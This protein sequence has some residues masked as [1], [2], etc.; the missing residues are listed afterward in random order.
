MKKL[1]MLLCLILS[2]L[3]IGC[4]SA[5]DQAR[6]SL[7]EIAQGIAEA[8]ERM[9]NTKP[10]LAAYSDIFE[11]INNN[12]SS[13][14]FTSSTSNNYN[15]ADYYEDLL[16]D[17]I[18]SIFINDAVSPP[19]VDLGENSFYAIVSLWVDESTVGVNTKLETLAEV[20]VEFAISEIM[21]SSIANFE[22]GSIIF[23]VTFYDYGSWGSYEYSLATKEYAFEPI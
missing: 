4:Q 14:S 12:E 6:S 18:P 7:N 16:E 1:T 11:N 21:K 20:S 15:D 17:A 10:D 9:R 22:N 8:S 2:F 23:L 3:L 5:E 19:Y 13:S